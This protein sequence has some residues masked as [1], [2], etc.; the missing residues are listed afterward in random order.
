MAQMDKATVTMQLEMP[1][2]DTRRTKIMTQKFMT[3]I[4][5]IHLRVGSMTTE[6]LKSLSSLANKLSSIQKLAKSWAS[7]L[8]QAACTSSMVPKPGAIIVKVG[9]EDVYL[10]EADAKALGI[11]KNDAGQYVIPGKPELAERQRQL[12]WRC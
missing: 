5:T 7:R 12:Q 10:T 3:L 1:G 8:M 6:T 2:K 9:K 4:R 11:K